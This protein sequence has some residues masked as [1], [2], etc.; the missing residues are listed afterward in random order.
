M[1]NK[2]IPLSVRISQE[3]A[4]FIASL[5]LEGAKTPSDK[6]RAIIAA[7]R[8]RQRQQQGDSY[9]SNLITSQEMLNGARRHIKE[10]E[11][12][13]QMHSELIS[14]LF[15]WIPETTAFLATAIPENSD[16]EGGKALQ[17]LEKGLIR[18]TATLMQSV[19]Q[20]GVTK[21]CPCYD[22]YLM[23][24]H[25]QP[26]LDIAELIINNRPHN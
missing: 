23:E 20:L 16:Q 22:E 6:V 12:R 8:Q 17:Q 3:D 5:E 2:S 18:R 19:L 24:K 25:L 10:I 13:Y 9:S 7:A 26:V 1:T 11:H 21:Q 4:E 15:D 14:R